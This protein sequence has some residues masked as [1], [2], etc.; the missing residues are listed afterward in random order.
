ML[1]LK[2]VKQWYDQHGKALGYTLCD[3]FG[4]LKDVSNAQIKHAMKSG[5]VNI[6]NLKITADNKLIKRDVD[7]Y[8]S[9]DTKINVT[10]SYYDY[11]DGRMIILYDDKRKQSWFL[12]STEYEKV[13]KNINTNDSLN[14]R[15]NNSELTL[16]KLMSSSKI[17]NYRDEFLSKYGE[18]INNDVNKQ[19]ELMIIDGNNPYLIIYSFINDYELREYKCTK[20]VNYITKILKCE[21]FE[22]FKIINNK[23]CT[24]H[25]HKP[26]LLKLEDTKKCE[27]VELDRW[28]NEE[29]RTGQ[30]GLYKF[31]DKLAD[32]KKKIANDEQIY[33]TFVPKEKTFLNNFDAFID[34]NSGKRILSDADIVWAIS[35]LGGL[36]KYSNIDNVNKRYVYVNNIRISQNI[37]EIQA[38][39]ENTK[40]VSDVAKLIDVSELEGLKS[41]LHVR[42][43]TDNNASVI[44]IVGTGYQVLVQIYM[45][46]A[47]GNNKKHQTRIR[48][49]LLKN[50]KARKSLY[51]KEVYGRN[52]SMQPNIQSIIVGNNEVTVNYSGVTPLIIKI[53]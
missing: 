24:P 13:V 20:D 29:V 17:Y 31:G 44:D 9:L 1:K 42:E 32:I 53:S 33:G 25:I 37:N 18:T 39:I 34:I 4:N 5:Q 8:D 52:T 49:E 48:M 14:E 35:K 6:V 51:N 2:A 3:E 36:H 41:A 38:I 12:P 21:G 19:L 11:S 47:K 28:R 45:T 16:E 23:I 26:T 15:Y 46:G 10:V 40:N 22:N 7:I 30:V 43:I 27:I 50:G